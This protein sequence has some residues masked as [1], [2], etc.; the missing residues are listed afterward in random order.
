MGIIL[1]CGLCRSYIFID[2]IPQF[3]DV[4]DGTTI[5]GICID[6]KEV[7]EVIEE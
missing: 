2:H 3:V 5:R 7:L 4:L 1:L 6:S